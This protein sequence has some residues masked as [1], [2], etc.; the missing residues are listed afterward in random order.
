MGVRG[1]CGDDPS[2]SGS[3]DRRTARRQRVRSRVPRRG[4]GVASIS[5][6]AIALT[7]AIAQGL[8][9]RGATVLTADSHCADSTPKG[10]ECTDSINAPKPSRGVTTLTRVYGRKSWGRAGHRRHPRRRRAP[11]ATQAAIVSAN[12]VSRSGTECTRVETISSSAPVRATSRERPAP[13]VSGLPM[14]WLARASSPRT[15]S[16]GE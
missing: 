10:S 7:G 8:G 14:T 16:A 5:S 1:H 15:C 11:E 2:R 3:P 6:S 13:T 12:D 9:L 4:R